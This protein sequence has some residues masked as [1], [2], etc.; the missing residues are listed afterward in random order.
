MKDITLQHFQRLARQN[1][2]GVMTLDKH[3]ESRLINNKGSFGQRIVS[4][5]KDLGQALGLGDSTRARRQQEA[6]DTFKALLEDRFG[7]VATTSALRAAG[8]AHTGRL[9]A[10]DV[11]RVIAQANRER[12]SN[13]TE[14]LTRVEK[15]GPPIAGAEPTVEF[16]RVLASF[17]P[18]VELSSLSEQTRQEYTRR[19]SDEC[20]G[21]SN[22]GGRPLDDEQISRLARSVLKHVLKLEAREQLD[23]ARSVRNGL[24]QGWKDL[25]VAVGSGADPLEVMQ[26]LEIIQQRTALLVRFETAPGDDVGADFFEECAG[27]AL[28]AALTELRGESPEL[29]RSLQSRALDEQGALKALFVAAN[30]SLYSMGANLSQTNLQFAGRVQHDIGTMIK[31]LGSVFGPRYGNLDNDMD[32]LSRDTLSQPLRNAGMEAFEEV[33]LQQFDAQRDVI[34]HYLGRYS[35]PHGDDEEPPWFNTEALVQLE[36]NVLAHAE[37]LGASPFD[38]LQDMHV[39][40]A[41]MDHFPLGLKERIGAALNA[42]KA[43]FDMMMELQGHPVFKALRPEDYWR[44]FA[45]GE[46]GHVAVQTK[47]DLEQNGEGSLAAM[48]RAFLGMVRDVGSGVVPD[49]QW[50]ERIQLSGS[51]DSY[52]NFDLVLSY[53]REL[54]VDES[55]REIAKDLRE[56]ARVPSGYRGQETNLRLRLDTQ[57]TP[58]GREALRELARTDPWFARLQETDTAFELNL[59]PRTSQECRERA[60]DILQ[61]HEQDMAQAHSEDEKLDVVARTTQDLYRS[62]VFMDGNTRTT[63]FC[64]LNGLLLK[65]GL[66]PCILPEPK[67]AAGF[68]QEEFVLEIRKGQAIFSELTTAQGSR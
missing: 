21:V 11:D 1:E 46:Q 53:K 65:A 67:A 57:T 63:V 2:S 42:I 8:L 28:M 6:F 68:S 36:Q 64:A 48:Q 20:L 19:L 62:H 61:R 24:Q 12:N 10:R 15:F 47:W 14:Q 4:G 27:T 55:T 43:G 16:A 7:E 66:S 18:P 35:K 34:E 17:D 50:L 41:A 5:F 26:R 40:L 38:V 32:R 58:A 44:L 25:L 51:Q 23:D 33:R 60:R 30:E 45:A 52:R 54:D 56:Q 59:A 29:L 37:Q 49:E 31:V 39:A 3:D 22:L 9:T 13:L